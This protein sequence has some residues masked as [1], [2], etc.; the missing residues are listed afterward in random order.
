MSHIL[1]SSKI[2]MI[3]MQWSLPTYSQESTSEKETENSGNISARS[4]LYFNISEKDFF[5][6]CPGNRIF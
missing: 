3:Q 6:N 4:I 5:K 1:N 2:K